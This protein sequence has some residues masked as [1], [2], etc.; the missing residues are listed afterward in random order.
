MRNC[1][2]CHSG[3]VEGVISGGQADIYF[4]VP[5]RVVT[6][7]STRV[8]A[9][10]CPECGLVQLIGSSPAPFKR[11]GAQKRRGGETVES[12]G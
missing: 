6:Q 1:P 11:L 2:E 7:Y 4:S 5:G 9:F 10:M 12:I 8:K 3:M